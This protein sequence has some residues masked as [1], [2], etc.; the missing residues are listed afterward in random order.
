LVGT[1]QRWLNSLGA[2]V[3][4]R[5]G[6]VAPDAGTWTPEHSAFLRRLGTRLA[7]VT[8]SLS[9]DAYSL[10]QAAEAL[11]R[12]VRDTVRFS[13]E[14]EE[15]AGLE[16]TASPSRTAVALELAAAWLLARC[17][18]PVMPRFARNL[19]AALGTDAPDT[20]PDVVTLLPP[21]SRVDLADLVFFEGSGASASDTSATA[22]ADPLL[23]WLSETVRSTLRLP[24][25]TPVAG[26][27]LTELGISSMQSVALQYQILEKAGVDITIE[28][29][30]GQQDLKALAVLLGALG[31][32]DSE[33]AD[34]EGTRA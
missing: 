31:K 24:A 26:R 12:I 25:D 19:A 22:D 9:E 13:A 23:G 17:A 29:M 28:Q 6:G 33:P 4:E 3:A 8:G 1:W 10:N 18:A 14:Q 2:R 16:T 7:E 21:G 27:S 5:Y 34:S 20:W 30:Y 32:A 11:D 15:A